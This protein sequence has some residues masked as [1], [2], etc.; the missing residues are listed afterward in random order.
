MKNKGGLL[1]AREGLLVAATGERPM[2]ACGEVLWLPPPPPANPGGVKQD[3]VFLGVLLCQAAVVLI[4]LGANIQRY[5]LVVVSPDRQCYCGIRCV[6]RLAAPLSGLDTVLTAYFIP[7]SSATSIW[8]LGLLT[9][10]GGNICFVFALAFAPASLCAALL[11]TVVVANAAIARLLL[12][13]QLQRCD[14]HGGLL[15]VAGEH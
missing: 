13:E 7:V 6:I 11:A 3:M 5:A 14:Y 10:F 1:C 9:Y 2:P 8:L 12:K 15:I 4:A